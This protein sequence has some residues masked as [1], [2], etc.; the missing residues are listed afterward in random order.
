MKTDYEEP[1]KGRVEQSLSVSPTAAQGMPQMGQA[2]RKGRGLIFEER[3]AAPPAANTQGR[4]CVCSSRIHINHQAQR[5]AK[6]GTCAADPGS[7]LALS[8]A[9]PNVSAGPRR[10][11]CPGHSEPLR[12][13][14]DSTPAHGVGPGL[15][16]Q[17]S[18]QATSRDQSHEV[19]NPR[20]FYE[21]TCRCKH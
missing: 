11:R 2:P 9:K 8:D 14:A 10:L 17:V 16:R 5:L 20:G 12:T 15:L 7:S 13:H 4:D 6:C 18:A 21:A 1:L 3:P 19:P